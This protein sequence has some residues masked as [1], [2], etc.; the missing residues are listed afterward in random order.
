LTNCKLQN[1]YFRV[2]KVC[3][4]LRELDSNTATGSDGIPA[5][6]L[7]N[8]AQELASPLAR[9]YQ[10]SLKT[11]CVPD[12]WKLATV[13]PVYKKG[14]RSDSANYRPI[15]LLPIVSKIMERIIHTKLSNHNMK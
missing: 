1:V 8:C 6:I 5:I 10:R 13:T 15:S 9:L 12:A 7:K 11:G 2:D 4:L 14:P 3:Q